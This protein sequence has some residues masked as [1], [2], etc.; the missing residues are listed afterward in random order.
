[1]GWGGGVVWRRRRTIS[2]TRMRMDTNPLAHKSADLTK[3]HVLVLLLHRLAE[4]GGV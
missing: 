1:V 3:A 4:L 2:M